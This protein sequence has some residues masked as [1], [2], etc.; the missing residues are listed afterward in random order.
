MAG[1]LCIQ[2]LHLGIMPLPLGGEVQYCLLGGN[3]R[4]LGSCR[5]DSTD[6]H[7]LRAD[8]LYQFQYLGDSSKVSMGGPC[9]MYICRYSYKVI[10][11]LCSWTQLR[12]CFHLKSWLWESISFM[13][14][15]RILYW[16]FN[17]CVTR[18][19][20]CHTINSKHTSETMADY[21]ACQSPHIW[22]KVA[23]QVCIRLPSK[24][25]YK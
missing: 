24:M 13:G 23:N 8:C 7:K 18:S 21:C 1:H 19:L 4:C 12:W 2:L 11:F 3:P 22:R 14:L 20:A 15:A 9:N 5:R 17:W 25:Y 16:I 10:Q 6:N